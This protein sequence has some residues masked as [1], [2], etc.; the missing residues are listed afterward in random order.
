MVNKQLNYANIGKKLFEFEDNCFDELAEINIGGWN[1]WRVVKTTLFF[2][3]IYSASQKITPESK[4]SPKFK[5]FSLYVRLFGGFCRFVL[6]FFISFIKSLIKKRNVFIITTSANKTLRYEKNKVMDSVVDH[7]ILDKSIKSFVY[8]EIPDASGRNRLKSVIPSDFWLTDLFLINIILFKLLK[9]KN[10]YYLQSTKLVKIWGDYFKESCPLSAGEI[11]NLLLNFKTELFVYEKLYKIFKPKLVL[12]ND[13]AGSGKVAAAKKMKISSIEL[14]HGLMDEYYPQYQLHSKFKSLKEKLPLADKIGVFGEFHKN[15]L[16][17]KGFYSEGDIFI[18]AKYSINIE[19]T[20]SI[21]KGNKA[22]LL[23]ITQGLPLFD[24]TKQH[25]LELL[26]SLDFQKF[27]L[28]V[29]IHPLEPFVCSNWY[30]SCLLRNNCDI[31]I[32]QNEYS[33]NE[34]LPSV[35]SVVGYTSTV[36]LEA[37]YHNKEVFSLTDEAY[38]DGIFSIIG[39]DKWLR[40]FITLVKDVD[41][42]IKEINKPRIK[43]TE[44]EDIS[45]YLFQDYCFI[46]YENS[47]N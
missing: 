2:T 44:V 17:N 15:Q 27:M 20:F 7:L 25:L 6:Q 45:H 43:N 40:S 24:Q 30:R 41:S 22:C 19:S 26:N 42:L 46:D 11:Q 32:I 1:A 35:N 34:I 9:K 8:A 18:A 4:K 36:L 39:E 31:K 3:V 33:I 29:K 38:P 47:F 23:F 21:D 12:L 16:L 14:Q 10:S 5:Q 28:V 37:V 13:Q